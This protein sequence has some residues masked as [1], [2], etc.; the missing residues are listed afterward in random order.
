[1]YLAKRLSDNQN[2]SVK[3]VKMMQLNEKERQNALNEIRLLASI[4]H[5]CIVSYKDAFFEDNTNC[6]CM[7][8]EY[9]DKGDFLGAIKEKQN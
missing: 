9:A 7:V 8:M 4:D 2:Y 1:V 6:L 3:K 5:P